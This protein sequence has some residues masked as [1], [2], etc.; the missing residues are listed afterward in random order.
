[1]KR[2]YRTEFHAAHHIRGH[3]RCGKTHG[4]TYRLKVTWTFSKTTWYDF[5]WL[6]DIIDGIVA[7]F[8]HQD[9]GDMECEKLAMLIKEIAMERMPTGA[10][11][12]EIELW[13]TAN[14]GIIL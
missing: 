1:M 8:D 11:D 12:I 14:F 3:P 13:E 5:H 6:K 9:L 4:H 7:K 2:I 10:I